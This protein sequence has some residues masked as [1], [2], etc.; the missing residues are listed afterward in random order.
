M[1]NKKRYSAFISYRHLPLDEKVAVRVQNMLENYRQP[2]GVARGKR[3]G[4]I[5][6]DTTELP[7]SEDLTNSMWFRDKSEPETDA[8]DPMMQIQVEAFY[9]KIVK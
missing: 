3:I 1:D 5:F 9:D 8:P 7:M 4:R 6:R 2:R